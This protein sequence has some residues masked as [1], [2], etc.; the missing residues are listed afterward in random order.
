M[1]SN[2][3]EVNPF[4]PPTADVDFGV[5]G[6]LSP[7]EMALADR[8][9]RLGA[10]LL[11]GVLYM[12]AMIPA[13]VVGV[14]SGAMRE[15]GGLWVFKSMTEG[16]GIITAVAWLGLLVFQAYLVSTAGQTLGKRWTKIKIVKMDGSPVNFVS[17]V[18]VRTWLLAVVQQIPFINVVIGLLDP[19]MIFRSDR[20]CLHDLIAGTKVVVAR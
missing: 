13:I 8:G 6:Q 1:D 9:T 7:D 5:Q 14:S 15:G 2:H 20:R 16:L 18:L 3:P 10:A 19:L 17:G 12:A 11:D 4:A